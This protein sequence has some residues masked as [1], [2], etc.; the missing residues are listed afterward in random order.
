VRPSRVR[1]PTLGRVSGEA[2]RPDGG[3]DRVRARLAAAVEQGTARAEAARD[4]WSAVDAL[5]DTRDRDRRVVGNVLAGAVAFRLFVYLLPLMLAVVTVLGIAFGLDPDSPDDLGDSLGLS[6]YVVESVTTASQES[7]R[8]LWVLVPL[9][10]WAI[11]TGGVG[12]AKVLHATHA[13]AWDQPVERLRHPALAALVAFG[14]ATAVVAS[15]GTLQ[16]LREESEGLG[17]GFVVLEVA[18]LVG[19]ALVVDLLLPRHPAARP[20]DLLPGAVLLGG[21]LWLLHVVSAY[22][23]AYRIA[24]SSELY[25]SLGVAAAL[26]AWLFVL[27]RLL[28]GS[29]VLNATLWQRRHPKATTPTG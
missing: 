24:S 17:L 13:L 1:A 27:G 12:A 23:L 29:A 6:R 9:T 5:F 11:Y 22:F 21:G 10:L 2:A 15:I 25:G 8:S 4:R 20:R 26:L 14:S 19:V 18:A 7:H 3:L 28:V 16:A